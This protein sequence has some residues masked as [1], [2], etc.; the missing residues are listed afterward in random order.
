METSRA[1]KRGEKKEKGK[2]VAVKESRERHNKGGKKVS[3]LWLCCR[4]FG[5]KCDRCGIVLSP[6]DLGRASQPKTC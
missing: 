4:I 3:K 6:H 1:N 2:S 5:V